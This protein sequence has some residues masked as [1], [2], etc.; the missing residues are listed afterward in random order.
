P[1]GGS[2][3]ATETVVHAAP[4]GHTLLLV[5]P[6]NAINV[7]LY[8]NL[9][10]D[11]VRDVAAVGG[12]MRVPLGVTGTP[13]LPAKTLSGFIRDAKANPD[14]INMALGGTGGVDHVAGLLF[15]KETGTRFQL[16]PYR[17]FAPALAD[18]LGGQ[19]QLIFSSIAATIEYI[20]AGKLRAL[21]VTSAA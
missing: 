15:Q 5:T 21:A 6:A 19:V 20:K 14:R 17:G 18:L 8:D 4:D 3:V 12:L 9:S 2:N 16:V 13:A 1:G 7:T 11:F 10:F